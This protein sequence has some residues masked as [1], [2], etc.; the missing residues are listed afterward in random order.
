MISF[1][2]FYPPRMYFQRQ[3]GFS[4]SAFFGLAPR[5]GRGRFMPDDTRLLDE[6]RF[7]FSDFFLPV[8]LHFSGKG[9]KPGI[10]GQ[11][12]D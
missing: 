8:F 6:I 12:A 10:H 7:H 4:F 3:L 11:M 2:G 9:K 5:L 1:M